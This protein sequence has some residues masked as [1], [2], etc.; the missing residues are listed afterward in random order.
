MFVVIAPPEILAAA[1]VARDLREFS[2]TVCPANAA[3]PTT[4]L[5][6]AP[7]GASALTATRLAAHGEMYQAVSA[8][9]EA[10]TVHDVLVTMRPPSPQIR[11]RS[12]GGVQ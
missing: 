3:P 10:G 6:S 1:A 9:A 7:D 11:C 5:T 4:E 2:F 12:V 8:Q